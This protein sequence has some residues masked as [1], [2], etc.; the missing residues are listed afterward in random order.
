MSRWITYS[1]GGKDNAN[2]DTTQTERLLRTLTRYS[3]T[4][5]PVAFSPDS[6]FLASDSGDRTCHWRTIEEFSLDVLKQCAWWEY[7]Y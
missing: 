1:Y 7:F 5:F 2:G 3:S 6:K 4:V